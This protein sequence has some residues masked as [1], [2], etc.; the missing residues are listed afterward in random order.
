MTGLTTN[1]MGKG[2]PAVA[3]TLKFYEHEIERLRNVTDGN[4]GKM[5]PSEV[6]QWDPMTV[7]TRESWEG[8]A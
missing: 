6:R 7:N 1:E 3:W 8:G 4:I 2:P 5:P